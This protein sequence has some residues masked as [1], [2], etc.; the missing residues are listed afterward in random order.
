MDVKILEKL[1]LTGNEIKIYVTLFRR[2]ISTTG[3]LMDELGL[4]SSR[5]YGSLK[6]LIAK[7]LVTYFVKNNTRYYQAENPDILLSEFENMKISIEKTIKEIK[8]SSRDEGEKEY[9]AIFEGFKGF[10]QAFEIVLKECN[11]KE[12][13]LTIGFSPPEHGFQTLRNYL[14][15]VDRERN[16]M[17]I[18]MKI[19][20]DRDMK[21]SVG[22]DREKEK[23]T[24][25]KYLPK[26]YVTPAAMSIF[27]DYVIHW[28][29]GKNPLIF[30]IKNKQI[31]ESFRSY[32]EL[33][34][35]MAKK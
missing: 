31:N 12:E 27:K 6:S 18:P 29:W 35:K 30:V 25:V 22:K 14:M 7:G 5:I 34:W 2:G 32:F 20:F 21:D 8:S 9:S 23:Y 17:K 11:K 15:K 19:I 26:G 28:A 10:K 4:S 13:L 16:K 33:L 3:P 24:Q 1:G